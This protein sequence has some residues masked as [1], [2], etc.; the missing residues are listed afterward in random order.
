VSLG[1]PKKM[2]KPKRKRRLLPKIPT[3]SVEESTVKGVIILWNG[4]EYYVAL[5][6]GTERFFTASID[7]S[8][9]LQQCPICS[10]QLTA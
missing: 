3:I 4:T 5:F 1:L 2:D 6:S 9:T 7:I 8:T 10:H